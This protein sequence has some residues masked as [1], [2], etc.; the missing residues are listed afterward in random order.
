MNLNGATIDSVLRRSARAFPAKPAV[1]DGARSLTYGQLDE[2]VDALAHALVKLGLC[3]GDR[4][5]VLFDNQWEMCCVYFALARIGALMVSLNARWLPGEIIY[6]VSDAACKAVI[7]ATRFDSVIADVRPAVNCGIW[8]SDGD[9]PAPSATDC[10]EG[11]INRSADQRLL[12]AW[13]VGESDD[14]GI[15]YTSGTSG[16]PKGAVV[17]HAS[18]V[19][20]AVATALCLRMDERSRL[21]AV[22]PMFHRGAMEDF[23]LA[24]FLVGATHVM[25]P[26]FDPAAMLEMIETHRITHA[27]I[28]PTMTWHVLS[29][30]TKD[31]YDLASMRAWMTASAP[32]PDEYRL[33]LE[34][35]TTL[36]RNVVFNCYGATESLLNTFLPPEAAASK[37]GSV[38]WPVPGT[39]VH[40]V[41][42]SGQAPLPGG[43]IG[44]VVTSTLTGA[45]TYWGLPDAWDAVTFQAEDRIWYRTGDLGY[46]DEDGCLYIVDRCKDMIIS[47]G[48]N[49]YSVEV[50]TALLQHPAIA[51]VAVVGLPDD[52]WGETVA[53]LVVAKHPRAICPDDVIR[54]SRSK[55]AGYKCPT[56]VVFADALPRNSFGKLQKQKVKAMVCGGL[57]G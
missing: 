27:F 52:R 16:R 34:R 41:S 1:I 22:A 55:L 7:Y 3:K 35:E 8:I 4:V 9:E 44:E 5:G 28:V 36:P 32:F 12:K 57:T 42:P 29:L 47:G 19:W 13:T 50:E 21:L 2:K 30:P 15:W 53:A 38:G 11:L 23:H 6:P 24:G 46:L 49:V 48:E 18:S 14:S 20:S 37:A 51:E 40:I 43:D 39:L 31:Q 33:R 45:R 54:W 10:M 26:R 56:K 17:R 25:L